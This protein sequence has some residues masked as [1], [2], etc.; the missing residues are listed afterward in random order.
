MLKASPAQ[1]SSCQ[2]RRDGTF[3][4]AVRGS[5]HHK[6]E[7]LH[8]SNADIALPGRKGRE[9]TVSTSNVR[10]DYIAAHGWGGFGKKQ[11]SYNKS[12]KFSLS[13]ERDST[14]SSVTVQLDGQPIGRAGLNVKLRHALASHSGG[15]HEYHRGSTWSW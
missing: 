13:L 5:E 1:N 12:P 10:T 2:I 3:E 15:S 6:R 7:I 8:R 14:L 11:T 9:A 4:S